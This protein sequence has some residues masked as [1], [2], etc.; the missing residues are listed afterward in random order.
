VPVTE[1]AA[2]R[3]DVTHVVYVCAFAMPASTSMLDV[4][5]GQP[6][7]WWIFAEDGESIMPDNPGRAPLQ[8]VCPSCGERGDR[9][10]ASGLGALGSRAAARGRISGETRNVRDQRARRDPPRKRGRT[11]SR[12]RAGHDRSLDSDHHPM[13]GRPAELAFILAGIVARTALEEPAAS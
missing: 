12:T 9:E 5:G 13:L 7:E 10:T 11:G 3:E 1:V 8:R 2:A 6:S 4:L